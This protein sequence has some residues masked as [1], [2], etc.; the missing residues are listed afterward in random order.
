MS[1]LLFLVCST[2]FG[3]F[4]AIA[5]FVEDKTGEGTRR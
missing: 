2:L 4:V 1:G 3:N 5:F